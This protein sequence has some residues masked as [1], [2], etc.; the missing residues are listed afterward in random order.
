MYDVKCFRSCGNTVV[1]I[2]ICIRQ[3]MYVCGLHIYCFVGKFYI[4]PLIS[5]SDIASINRLI[6]ILRN[7]GHIMM[8]DTN[9]NNNVS[10]ECLDIHYHQYN[11]SQPILSDTVIL[12]IMSVSTFKSADILYVE[13]GYFFNNIQSNLPMQSPALRGH[14]F[15]VI[16]KFI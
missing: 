16:E 12:A 14:P 3:Q 4:F 9:K 15:L 6:L 2:S 8:S 11:I 7:I 5:L 1:P 13:F 10:F